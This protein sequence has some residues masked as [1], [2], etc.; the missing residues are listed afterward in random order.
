MISTISCNSLDEEEIFIMVLI[1]L[2]ML[3]I[4][5]DLRRKQVFTIRAQPGTYPCT[6]HHRFWDSLHELFE[7][8]CRFRKEDFQRMVHVMGLTGQVYRCGRRGK[9][10]CYPAELCLMVLLCRISPQHISSFGIGIWY[11]FE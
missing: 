11:R 4:E 1:F 8:L 7:A 9:Q 10:Q 3:N 6:S 5:E 2:S